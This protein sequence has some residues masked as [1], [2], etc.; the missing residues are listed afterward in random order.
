MPDNN[1]T[2]NTNECLFC[3][4]ANKQTDSI[5]ISETDKSIAFLDIKP[6]SPGHA[7]I[8][9][10]NHYQIMQQMSDEDISELFVHTQT[11]S[12]SMLIGLSK[13]GYNGTSILVCQ[14][15]TAGQKASHL[16]IHIIPQKDE[17]RILKWESYKE[18][19]QKVYDTARVLRNIVHGK[20]GNGRK[21]DT[22]N[23]DLDT[24]TKSLGGQK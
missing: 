21:E 15:Q 8:I 2:D 19:E 20:T 11:I 12:H 3:S 5:I 9:P 24:L 10:K 23:N 18:D 22:D 4:I 6:A 13:E 14:G 1:K 16:M 7:I 17:S